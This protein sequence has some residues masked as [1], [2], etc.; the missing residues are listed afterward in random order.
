M[1]MSVFTKIEPLSEET[2]NRFRKLIYEKT[3]INMRE[4]KHILL[5]NRL[6]KRILALNLK[7]F[8][9]YYRYLTEGKSR[10]ELALF[11]D[12]VSTNETYFF[13]EMNH[14]RILKEIIFPELLKGQKRIRLWSA[15]CST[16]EE[17]YTLR[18]IFEEGKDCLYTGE[19]EI[20]ATDISRE[21]IERAREGVYSK[22]SLRYVPPAIL[23][24]YF[25]S[26]ENG[27]YSVTKNLQDA[28]DFRVHNLLSEEPLE[29]KFDVIICRNV[30]IYFDKPTQKRLVDGY[31][32]GVLAPTGYLCIGHSESLT[33]NSEKFRYVRALKAPI[34]R[35]IEKTAR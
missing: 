13:R 1:P 30:M 3:N 22:R 2:F 16:G 33:G 27:L 12:A 31:F 23:M 4:S 24:R 6:R 29:R 9:E 14:Y 20:I 5:S 26:C 28:V 7:S 17:A 25:M 10:E 18:I 32:A 8:D 34:Y 35:K 21:V 15:G 11:I 19:A